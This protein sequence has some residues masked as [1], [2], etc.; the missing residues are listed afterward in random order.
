MQKQAPTFGR[1]FVM[2]GF[3]LSCFGL[4]LFLWLAFG[5]PVPLQP[6]GYRF[7]TSFAE[8]TQLAKEA[9]V[10][11]SG[12]SVGKV[13]SIKPDK[14]TGRAETVIE[15]EP[16]YSPIP[17]DTK[18]IL[19]Q[20]TLLGETYVELTPGDGKKA[21]WVPENGT[22][23]DSQISPTVELDEIFRA[24]DPRTRAAFQN[25]MQQLAIG[26]KGRGQDISDALGNLTPF[27]EDTNTLLEILNSQSDAVRQLVSNTGEVFDALSERRGQLASL[28]QNS[29]TVFAT[30]AKR[31]KELQQTFVALPA[32]EKESK[33]TIERLT[34]FANATNPLI[35]QLR[36]AAREISPTLVDLSA[37]APDLKALFRDIDPLITISKTGL[38]ATQKFLDQLHPVLAEFDPTLRQLNPILSFLGLYKD[39][40]NSFFANT[41]ASTQ[42][43]NSAAGDPNPVH[44]LRT[45][46]PINLENLA[47]YAKRLGS[48]RP[49]A[50]ALPGMFRKLKDGLEVYE[51]R[52]CGRGVLPTL[53]PVNGVTTLLGGSNLAAQ[54]S[55]TIGAIGGGSSPIT[56]PAPKCIK[57]GKFTIDGR[58]TTFPQVQAS[59]G[60][61]A[62]KAS[63]RKK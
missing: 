6:K 60:A 62:R 7:Q 32:F 41:V 34:K 16:K 53:G 14:K 9:D 15:M 37:L 8:A 47:V 40:I 17:K 55:Q 51:D 49:N 1:I 38:P 20:K 59:G 58:S 22:L 23:P 57:Q 52:Q 48:N 46:N 63:S 25:W 30:T 45:T 24:F 11:I 44:Y 50:Y 39:E 54:L 10:R 31:D 33:A 29:N 28:I 36:P 56:T 5:G 3:A 2:V 61:V 42:V 26:T 4:L 43:T 27:A 18:A 12:V 13:K 19:R 21:G 35:N